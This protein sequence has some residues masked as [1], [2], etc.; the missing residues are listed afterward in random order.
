[1]TIQLETWESSLLLQAYAPLENR[2]RHDMQVLADRAQSERAYL[3]C[4]TLT[5]EH[6]HT[7]FVASA[8][9]PHAQRKAIRALYAFCRTSDDLVDNDASDKAS[10]LY[11]WRQLTLHDHAHHDDP[12]SLAWADTRAR[13]QIPRQYAEQLLDGVATDL[14]KTRYQTFDELAQY[15]Y[16]VASTVGLMSMHIVGY[17]GKEAIPYAV[18]LGVALQLTNILRDVGEDWQNGRLYLPQDELEAFGLTEEDIDQGIVDERW[19]AFMRFQ[20]ERARQLYAEALPGVV[21]LDK[22]GRLAIAAAAEL[23]QAI[24]DDIEAN[25]Y[26]VFTRRAH[27]STGRK[28]ALLP[29]IW[30]RSRTGSYTAPERQPAQPA[31][32]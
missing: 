9:L 21:M 4:Q 20:I 11:H 16:A 27:V 14:T 24:L 17:S 18:K 32:V 7:F 25:D 26:D 8:L 12:V 29:G 15:S 6:S 1:M 13:Y 10:K 19:R 22:K 23:Y 3:H 28:L 31:T 5:R 30:W 2:L